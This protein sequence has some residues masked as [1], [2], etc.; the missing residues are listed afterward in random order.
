MIPNAE[1]G[2]RNAEWIGQSSSTS[3][4]IENRTFPFN[5][6]FRVPRSAFGIQDWQ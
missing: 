5:S 4:G 3:A 2:M 6:A 1:C